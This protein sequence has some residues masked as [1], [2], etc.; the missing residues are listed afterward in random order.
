MNV[1]VTGATGFVG[2]NLVPELLSRGFDVKATTRDPSSYHPPDGVEVMEAD[3]L[4]RDSLE[5]VFD[6]VDAAFYLVHSLESGADF[7]ERDRRAARNFADAAGEAGVDRVVY[8]GGLGETGSDLSE[9]LRSRREVEQ[10]LEGGE[11]DLTTL[12]AAIIVGD[13]SASFQMIRELAGRLPIMVTP[14][15]VRTPCQPIAVDDVVEYLAG[16]LEAPETADDTFEI[17]GPEVLTY[18]EIL[19]RTAAKMGKSPLV[20]PVPVLSPGLSVYWVDLVTS[21]SRSVAHPLIYGLKEP[22]VVTD[23]RIR[24]MVPVE[25]KSFDDAVERALD[26]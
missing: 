10:V 1:L 17:G 22:V 8:L 16:V 3:L 4:D 6:G 9:H 21:V 11:Y 7:A 25:L 19:E 24:E 20:I 26:G 18:Q 23:D 12:R 13:G 14:K 5:G 2:G 15:W